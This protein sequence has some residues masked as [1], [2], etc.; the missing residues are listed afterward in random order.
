MCADNSAT[1]SEIGSGT[2]SGIKDVANRA[3]VSISTVSNVLNKAKYV[4]PDLVKKVEE[5]VRELDYQVNPIAA[6]MKTKKSGT[7]GVITEDMCGVFYPYI[8]K[9]INAIAEEKGYKIIIGDVSGGKGNISASEKE[10]ELFQKLLANRVDGIIFTSS[11]SEG[12]RDKYFLKLKKL[13]DHKQKRTPIVSLERDLTKLGI[14]SVYFDGYAN[15]QKATGHLIDCGCKTI[16]HISGPI[17]LDIARERI[18]GYKKCLKDNQKRLDEN[19]MIAYGDYTHQSGYVAME[20]LLDKVPELDGVFCGNDQMAIGA[21]KALKK[22]KKKV[23]EEVKLIGYDDVFISSI[24]EPSISTIH[25]QK[26]TAGRKAAE[27]LFEQI[28]NEESKEMTLGIKMESY[29]VVRKSTRKD[30][31]EDWNLNDW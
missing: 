6:S 26:K 12:S 28:E 14:N 13:A 8:V 1:K 19:T 10:M 9:G 22:R 23:P 11:I 7:I 30:A 2:M 27:L 31:A 24:V 3:G 29:L 4:S 16:C 21:L 15:A 17:E 5:A 18:N 25:I 20:E